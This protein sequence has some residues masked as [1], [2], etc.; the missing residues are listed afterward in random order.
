M[1]AL[2][3]PP[4]ERFSEGRWSWECVLRNHELRVAAGVV[5]GMVL[6]KLRLEAWGPL[7]PGK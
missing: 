1:L 7:W 2:L 3:Q 5:L 6:L 4:R